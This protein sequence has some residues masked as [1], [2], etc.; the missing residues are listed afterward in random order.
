LNNLKSEKILR[1]DFLNKSITEFRGVYQNKHSKF[2]KKIF[3]PPYF[4]VVYAIS[5]KLNIVESAR[6]QD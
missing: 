4:G 1:F 2:G 5:V 3:L 6:N